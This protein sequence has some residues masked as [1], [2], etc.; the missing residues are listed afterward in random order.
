[1]SSADTPAALA[2]RADGRRTDTRDRLIASA[3]RMFNE[4][5]YART[6]VAEIERSV[7]L[8]PGGGGLYRHF[9]SKDEL[10][11]EAVH[12]Y[13]R[14][15]RA[16]RAELDAREPGPP[17]A[18]D[19]RALVVA[20][21]E[22]LAGE[23][24]MVRLSLDTGGLPEPV[25]HAVGEAWDDG[26]GMLADLLAR[27]GVEREEATM[28]AVSMLGSLNHYFTHI[29]I[30]HQQPAGVTPPAFLDAWVAQVCALCPGS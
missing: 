2:A 14:R 12:A 20:L 16:L 21:A 28:V 18:D 7:G 5:G 26:Y 10:L 3:L 30:W 19:L 24:P 29:G 17:M 23:G 15:V 4:H 6:T 13:G 9:A 27:R 1:M 22:F 25:R 11:L 8:R